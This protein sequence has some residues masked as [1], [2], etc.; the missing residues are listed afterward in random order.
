MVAGGIWRDYALSF[1]GEAAVF[2][3]FT[4]TADRPDVQI[5]KRPALARK[6]G[7][8]ALIGQNGSVLKRGHELAPLVRLLDRRLLK[9]VED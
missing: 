1:T 3:G 2:S 6:Q 9:L 4:R 7:A 8:F 5:V